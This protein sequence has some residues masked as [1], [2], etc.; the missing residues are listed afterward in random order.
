M[1]QHHKKQEDNTNYSFLLKCM[2]ALTAAAVITTGVIAAVSLKSA[3]AAATTTAIAAKMTLASAFIFTPIIPIA[4]VLIGLVCV[5]PFL[6]GRN[7]HTYIPNRIVTTG[8]N[9]FGFYSPP[10]Y[11][12]AS[13][14]TDSHYH[15]QGTGTVYTTNSHVHGHDNPTTHGHDSH[16]HGHSTGVHMHGHR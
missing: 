2:A 6:F 4:L 3:A 14:Y 8:Y 13:V 9:N 1:K 5:L 10:S 12:T 16:T 15:N 7:N 11:S